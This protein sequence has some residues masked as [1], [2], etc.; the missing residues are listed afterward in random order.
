M[1]PAYREYG[2]TI[3]NSCP[4]EFVASILKLIVEFSSIFR[5]YYFELLF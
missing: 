2:T 4:A 5:Y 3:D 1:V